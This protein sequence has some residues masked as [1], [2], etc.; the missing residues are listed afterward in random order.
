M[1]TI[2]V[3]IGGMADLPD[4]ALDGKTPLM[5]ADIPS[6]NV[7]A[8]DGS[9]G[10][11]TPGEGLVTS[12]ADAVLS[13]LG[14]DLRKG[15]ATDYEYRQF[16]L[17]VSGI[18]LTPSLSPIVIPTFSGH[19]TVISPSPLVRGILKSAFM[20]PIDLYAPGNSE[21]DLLEAMAAQTISAAAQSQLVTVFV[22]GPEQASRQGDPDGKIES[23]EMIDAHL[24]TPVADFVWRS[25]E[26]MNLVVTTDHI[27]SWRHKMPVE[28]Q[29]PVLIYFNDE[30]LLKK[31]NFNEVTASEGE[32]NLVNPADLMRLLYPLPP[33][34]NEDESK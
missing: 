30:P 28:G 10:I 22:D 5:V 11:I 7:L 15:R 2:L 19:G 23:L 31:R 1:K 33:A 21:T 18:P 9:L 6:L 20:Y 17:E 26:M 24:I 34:S 13:M 4:R 16:G 29:V 32:L 27:F 8:G 3:I 25:D 12:T 14:Y